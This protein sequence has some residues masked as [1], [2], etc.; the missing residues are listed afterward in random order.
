M[1]VL[2]LKIRVGKLTR[3]SK[4]N[5]F[6]YIL[7]L[8]DDK[9]LWFALIY[10]IVISI[11]Y[12]HLA[13]VAL[14]MLDFFVRFKVSRKV[15]III[16][17]PLLRIIYIIFTTVTI[18][19]ITALFVEEIGLGLGIGTCDSPLSCTQQYFLISMNLLKNLSIPTNIF[20]KLALLSVLPR[21]V[22]RLLTSSL[23][24]GVMLSEKRRRDE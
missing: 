24:I 20:G 3:S 23:I 21:F 18:I 7:F 11:S 1:E 22:L 17:K 8:L 14:L 9:T 19:Y 12:Y 2:P 16:T 15:T 13:F 4:T 6:K 10:T 5:N